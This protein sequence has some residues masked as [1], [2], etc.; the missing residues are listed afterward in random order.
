[1]T[2]AWAPDDPVLGR[3]V[4]AS[5]VNR[6]EHGDALVP[7][8]ERYDGGCLPLLRRRLGGSPLHRGRIRILCAEHG[9]A[10][11]DTQVPPTPAML[12]EYSAAQLRPAV[13]D[14]L[15]TEFA[16]TGVPREVLVLADWP[17]SLL[18]TDLF[19][20]PGRAPYASLYT[21]QPAAHE[22]QI[23]AALDRWGWP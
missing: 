17:H 21:N 20:L 13:F 18:L 7:A 16:R 2:F 19:H 12:D 9:L 11:A 23:N 8:L 15:L 14:L 4:F 3:M 1:M 6:P 10:A 5:G 22:T